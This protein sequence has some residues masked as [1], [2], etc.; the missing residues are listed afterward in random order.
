[1]SILMSAFLGLV[2]GIAEFLP[3]SSSGH[4]SI[5]QNLIGLK[6]CEDD[7][8]F[9]DVLL[10]LGTLVSICIVYRE[11]ILKMIRGVIHFLRGNCD[12][13]AFGDP[14]VP[15]ARQAL[16]I[17][18]A[19]VPLLIAVPFYSRIS[20]LYSKTGFIGFA[21]L[22]TGTLLFVSDKYVGS[23]KKSENTMTVADALMIGLGQMIALI[24]G[25][26]RS[27]T[28]ITVGMSRRLDRNYAVRFSLLMSI[29]AILGS[30][31]LSLKDALEAGIDW[32]LMPT[33]LVG[34]VFSAVVGYFSIRLLNRIMNNG[35]FGHFSYYCWAVGII[36]IL[37]SIIL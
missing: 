22:I 7:H 16:L 35:R 9:F 3:I 34:F 13:S 19:T 23:G 24:P 28:T 20:S 5:L 4:L 2:Q 32:S 6:Y 29:P 1:M 10:H 37:L 25:L 12:F 30:L 27:G 36:T 15:P 11:D 14:L 8:L 33:Y 18:I 26:S 17:I 31:V 21:L